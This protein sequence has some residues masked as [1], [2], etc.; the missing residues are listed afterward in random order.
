MRYGVG[1][2]IGEMSDLFNEY[3]PRRLF[4]LLRTSSLCRRD[5]A[6]RDARAT[7]SWWEA[8]R[9]PFNLIVGSAGILTCI[10]VGV[11]GLGAEI[12]FNS[13]FGMP[14]PPG[15][16]LIGIILYGIA[17]NICFTG[18]WVVELFV[19]EFWPSEADRFATWSF[20]TGLVFSVLLTL[21]PAVVIGASGLFG[22]LRHLRVH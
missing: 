15:F 12:L 6:V 7:I 21:A 16:A 1:D 10:V 20:S 14:N 2:I 18:G 9:I 11:V 22:L 4:G 19:R 17:A 5:S 8:R 13:E 3:M